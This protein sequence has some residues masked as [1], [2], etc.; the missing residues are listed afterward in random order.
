MPFS[1]KAQQRKCYL[2]KSQGKAGS[3]NCK[4]WSKVTNQKTLP[5]K[6]TK[7]RK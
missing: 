4:E 6:V 2:L 3:W 1:S 5:K 7:K